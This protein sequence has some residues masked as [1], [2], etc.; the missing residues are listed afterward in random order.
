MTNPLL[1]ASLLIAPMH[2]AFARDDGCT[3]TVCATA[4]VFQSVSALR[5][6]GLLI[7]APDSGCRHV[8]YRVKSGDTLLGNT[9]ALAPGELAVVHL[10]QGFPAGETRLT[11]A[12]VGCN[13]SPAATRRVVLAKAAPDHG[14]RISD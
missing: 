14:W 4:V 2:P 12:S 6:Y 5:S 7:A 1:L 10:G 11:V 3:G 9:P 8:R 13:A